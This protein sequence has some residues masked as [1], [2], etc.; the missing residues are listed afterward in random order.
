M[1]VSSSSRRNID[2]RPLVLLVILIAAAFLMTW[3]ITQRTGFGSHAA[4]APGIAV[5][6][7]SYSINNGGTVRNVNGFY[8]G[9]YVHFV[10]SFFS[11]L[12]IG[13]FNWVSSLSVV[14][15]SANPGSVKISFYNTS[16]VN[17]AN[18]QISNI[19]P[20]GFVTVTGSKV[21]LPAGF[22]GSAVITTSQLS[23][24][25]DTT[26]A[27]GGKDR[28]S[29]AIPQS[30]AGT[31]LYS[32]IAYNKVFNPTLN[33][34]STITVQNITQTTIYPGEISVDFYCRTGVNTQGVPGAVYT[35]KNYSP[36]LPYTRSDFPLRP[37]DDI[38]GATERNY[39]SSAFFGYAVVRSVKP[40]VG[41]LAITETYKNTTREEALVS[42]LSTVLYAPGLVQGKWYPVDNP[43]VTSTSSI[44]VSNPNSVAANVFS[45]FHFGNLSYTLRP[46]GPGGN[47]CDFGSNIPIPAWGERSVF[48][49]WY[50]PASSCWSQTS[51]GTG[52]SA[53]G[54]AKIYSTNNIPID[55]SYNLGGPEDGAE[56]G[57]PQEN[58]QPT[59][60]VTQAFKNFINYNT[61][62]V[63]VNP[64]GSA[65]NY[66]FDYYD[67]SGVLKSHRN[68]YIGP[69]SQYID[70]T[71][72]NPD[73]PNG[74]SFSVMISPM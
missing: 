40:I 19:N 54:W 38:C 22:M 70:D 20:H 45:E 60:Y 6:Q 43:S 15:I 62:I 46:G 5:E 12:Y 29:Q 72:T 10:P 47:N 31:T 51:F 35:L 13:G 34:V 41:I 2:S 39:T 56:P 61:K 48:P 17:I 37:P 4:S 55:A 27:S 23:V 58:I 57:I 65:G 52:N 63:V 14:N 71:K 24:A 28:A 42:R 59:A 36:V 7:L 64:S 25:E 3:M 8:K 32:P 18:Y 9:D 11:N 49:F 26:G 50:P 16:G 66:Y 53:F 1:S 73:L 67:S 68:H 30:S 33:Y 21:G 74:Q 69:A 44:N